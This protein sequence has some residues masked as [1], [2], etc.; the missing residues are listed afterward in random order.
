MAT[1]HPFERALVETLE[2]GEIPTS[3]LFGGWNPLLVAASEIGKSPAMPEFLKLAVTEGAFAEGSDLLSVRDFICSCIEIATD[4]LVLTEAVDL[5]DGA[6]VLSEE[7]KA[8]CFARFLSL[9]A[10]SEIGLMARAAALDGSF[11]QAISNRKFQLKLIAFLVDIKSDEHPLFLVRA[12]KI[13]GVAYSHWR[14]VE[15]LKQLRRFAEI[16]GAE[17]EAS[18]ELGMARLTDGFETN[19][20][21]L[22]QEAFHAAR[23]WFD[24]SVQ[25]REQ[26]PDAAI[27]SRCLE[28]LES[29]SGGER[30]ERL[31]ELASSIT[32]YAFQMDAWHVNDNDPPWLGTRHV[33]GACW[34]M[35]AL[36]LRNLSSE[37]DKV[38]WWEPAAVIREYVLTSYVA[39]R[40]ILK[41]SK[42]GG[43][44]EIIRPRIESSIVAREG[45]AFA[46]KEWLRHHSEDEWASSARELLGKVDTLISGYESPDPSEAATGWAPVAALIEQAAIPS[47]TKDEILAAI[48]DAHRLQLTGISAAEMTIVDDCIQAVSNHPDYREN[49]YGRSLFRVVVL[50]TLRFLTNRLEMTKGHAPN[51][52]YL[53]E[54]ADGTLPKESALQDDYYQFMVS[55]LAG[56]VKIEVPDVGS[57]RADVVFKLGSERLVVEVKR[58]ASNSS[59]L[60]LEKSYASQASDYQNVSIRLGLLLVLDQTEIRRSGTPH[61]STLVHP[62]RLVREGE[63]DPRWIV[64]VKV[65]GRRVTPS[66]LSK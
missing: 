9:A 38:S 36:T 44:E 1:L 26:R 16:S 3:D 43:I 65:P 57:G 52:T 54:N 30:P 37:L 20:R 45:Q 50:Y 40:S 7:D 39:S 31:E 4:D 13:I 19:D 66:Q 34:A 22:A 17:D 59:F 35:L 18:F 58:E 46:L 28:I 24:V 49:P 42:T 47:S 53:F 29:F 12:A 21:S 64:I 15:L 11:R 55:A 27:Y 10:D 25:Q 62:L 23:H 60:S 61:I 32:D 6:D 5:L 51:M 8:R 41:R 2:R 56:T 63:I 33:E 48:E 14:E